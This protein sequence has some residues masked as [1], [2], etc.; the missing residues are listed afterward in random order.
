MRYVYLV[1]AVDCDYD[2]Y[3][4]MVIVADNEE[5]ARQVAF[6]EAGG[7]T[8][9]PHRNANS[10]LTAPVV[11]IGNADPMYDGTVVLKSFNAG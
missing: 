9:F 7:K 3:D 11:M 4:S 8:R 2:E 5:E 6:V 1:G 10:F